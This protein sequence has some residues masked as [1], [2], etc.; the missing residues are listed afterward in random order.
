MYPIYQFYMSGTVYRP[1][2]LHA[3]KNI[4][5]TNARIAR[6]KCSELLSLQL[7]SQ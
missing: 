3:R 2:I 1:Y 4:V 5:A 7:H 6:T